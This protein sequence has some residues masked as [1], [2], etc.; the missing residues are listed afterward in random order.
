MFYCILAIRPYT[1]PKTYKLTY[2][3]RQTNKTYKQQNTQT[4]NNS[5]TNKQNKNKTKHQFVK[6]V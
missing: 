4:N 6:L 3:H 2:A 5:Q 1:N